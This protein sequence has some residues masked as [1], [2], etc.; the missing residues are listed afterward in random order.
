[1]TNDFFAKTIFSNGI[2]LL[3]T[4]SIEL[5]DGTSITQN[6]LKSIATNNADIITINS[7]LAP[8]S[9]T[10]NSFKIDT[11]KI[12]FD[13]TPN[14][15]ELSFDGG[16]KYNNNS[17]NLLDIATNKGNIA[18]NTSNIATNTSNIATNTSN[19]ATNTSNIATNTSNIATN[20]GD[21]NLISYNI[22]S[23]VKLAVGPDTYTLC[24]EPLQFTKILSNYSSAWTAIHSHYTW[25]IN[26]NLNIYLPFR[27]SLFFTKDFSQINYGYTYPYFGNLGPIQLPNDV[28]G[29]NYSQNFVSDITSQTKVGYADF[30]HSLQIVNGNTFRIRFA[31]NVCET[32]NAGGDNFQIHSSGY[33]MLYIFR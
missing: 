3:N 22:D 20:A 26:H 19:I 29:G 6:D 16:L 28:V 18:T 17:V 8:V 1:L 2:K 11:D 13:C 23:I 9:Y 21:I 25:V 12:T 24:Q 31:G 14:I 30:G 10:A 27:Y 15:W 4:S 33:V 7:T 5:N 32:L